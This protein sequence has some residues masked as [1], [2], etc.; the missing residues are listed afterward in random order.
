M[1]NQIPNPNHNISIPQITNIDPQD[2]PLE[3]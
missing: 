1:P 2:M 3:F